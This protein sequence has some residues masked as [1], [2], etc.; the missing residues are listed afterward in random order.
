MNGYVKP[1]LIF[2]IQTNISTCLHDDKKQIK[3]TNPLNNN[4]EIILV[5]RWVFYLWMCG[6]D[7]SD[8][9]DLLTNHS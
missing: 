8:W 4:I 1:Q 9:L 7:Y 6:E 3:K 5:Y 2:V